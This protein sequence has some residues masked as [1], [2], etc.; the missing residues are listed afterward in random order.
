M[1]IVGA[2]STDRACL[3]LRRGSRVGEMA[4]RAPHGSSYSY[5]KMKA[6]HKEAYGYLSRALQIDESGVGERRHS[7]A[8]CVVEL[9]LDYCS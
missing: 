2:W 8:L 6:R 7:L 3:R 9:R 1:N 5:E 4:V